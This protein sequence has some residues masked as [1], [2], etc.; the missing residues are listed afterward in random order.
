MDGFRE[1][2]LD[3]L[4]G[5]LRQLVQG[6]MLCSS[7]GASLAQYRRIQQSGESML[8]NVVRGALV[9]QG[10]ANDRVVQAAS[11]ARRAS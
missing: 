3:L 10:I 8:V 9:T 6:A 11:L 5:L 2:C 1:G 7:R 4:R